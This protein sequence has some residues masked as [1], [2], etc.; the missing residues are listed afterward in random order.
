ML[1]NLYSFFGFISILSFPVLDVGCL[2]W[3]DVEDPDR[4]VRRSCQLGVQQGYGTRVL[5]VL[6]MGDCSSN[7][8]VKCLIPNICYKKFYPY[9]LVFAM[10]RDLPD[11]GSITLKN[12]SRSRP[13]YVKRI[14]PNPGSVTLKN[15]SG[16]RVRYVKNGSGSSSEAFFTFKQF[17]LQNKIWNI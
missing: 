2:D 5:Q 17:H 13:L 11:P 9:K 6:Y 15:G 12:R 7:Y 4:G 3:Q 14:D 8:Q 1:F 16:S 10:L